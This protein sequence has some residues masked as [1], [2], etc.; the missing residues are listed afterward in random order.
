MAKT[1]TRDLILDISLQLL[2]E[3]GESQLTSVDIAHEMNISPGN[4]YYHFKGKEE[5]VEELYQDFHRGLLA[6]LEKLLPKATHDPKDIILRLCLVSDVL[7]QY[8]FISH[9]IRGLSS[10]YLSLKPQLSRL[11]GLLYQSLMLLIKAMLSNSNRN[12]PDNISPIMAENVLAI[13]LNHQAYDTLLTESDST[14]F[15]DA[16]EDRLFLLFLPYID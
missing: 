12:L 9:D 11:L 14:E 10:R 7:Q 5:I 16:I 3:R 1:K 6:T 15:A 4:L 2:N 13:L 8:R